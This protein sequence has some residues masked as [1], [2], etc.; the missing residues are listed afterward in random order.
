[1]ADEKAQVEEGKPK[2][3]AGKLGPKPRVKKVKFIVNPR[4]SKRTTVIV[5]EET[6]VHGEVYEAEE[7]PRRYVNFMGGRAAALVS[8]EKL[9]ASKEE[10]PEDVLDG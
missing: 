4:F 1:M 3:G 10:L 7:I 9:P 2:R 6:Y 5:G 8:V